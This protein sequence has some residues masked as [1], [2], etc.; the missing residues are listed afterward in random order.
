[1]GVNDEGRSTQ[2]QPTAKK[3]YQAGTGAILLFSLPCEADP[4]TSPGSWGLHVAVKVQAVLVV[5]V[6]VVSLD[7]LVIM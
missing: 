5:V 2:A 7:A 4:G 6:V 3:E 1:M